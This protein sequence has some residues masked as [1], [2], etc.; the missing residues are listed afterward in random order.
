MALLG[1]PN[2]GGAFMLAARVLGSAS[3]AAH[4]A[5]FS[6]F[7]WRAIVGNGFRLVSLAMA[8]V[9]AA[10]FAMSFAGG[11]L[12]KHGGRT[13]ARSIGVWLVGGS[14]ALASALLVFASWGD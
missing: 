6:L 3:S 13:K 14:A 12:I 7:V 10:G 2:P 8:V 4:V 5:F 9:A 11:A 1:L